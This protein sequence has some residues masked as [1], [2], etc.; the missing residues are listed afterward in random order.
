MNYKTICLALLMSATARVHALEMPAD[1]Q[2][3]LQQATVSEIGYPSGTDAQI[4]QFTD[5][6][7][8]NWAA[9]LASIDTIAPDER[10]QRVIAAGA[11]FLAGSDYLTFLSGLLDKY[12]A[13]KVKK[14]VAV[15]AMMADGKKA[16]FLAYNYQNQV[17][18]NLCERAKT[19]FPG[20]A[21]L[22]TSMTEILSGVQKRQAAL[23]AFNE[24]RPEPELLPNN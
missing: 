19:V 18:R 22:Q 8:A 9:I 14:A 13:N 4:I 23:A 15:E 1:I 10:R 20:E 7:K 12:Q 5:Y 11:E 3:Y 24:G 17:V 16:G 2:T 21:A 6:V